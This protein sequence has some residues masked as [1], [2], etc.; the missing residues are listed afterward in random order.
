VKIVGEQLEVE[1]FRF[2]IRALALEYIDDRE[3]H[4]LAQGTVGLFAARGEL[5]INPLFRGPIFIGAKNVRRVVA[6]Q[7]DGDGG[8]DAIY[9]MYDDLKLVPEILALL[10]L[11]SLLPLPY[12]RFSVYFPSA[13]FSMIRSY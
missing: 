5:G 10:S 12:F 6:K 1:Q 9:G 8:Q 2:N 4:I 7:G 11:P 13:C 3:K